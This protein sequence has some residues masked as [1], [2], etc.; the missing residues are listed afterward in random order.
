MQQESIVSV[1][2]SILLSFLLLFAVLS[3]QPG[4]M[5]TL[6]FGLFA[7]V[8]GQMLAVSVADARAKGVLTDVLLTVGTIAVLFTALAFFDTQNR[9]LGFGPYL[10]VALIGLIIARLIVLGFVVAD[11]GA[12][13]YGVSN[14]L[15]WFASGLFA[16]YLAY[17]TQLMKKRIAS[18][19]RQQHDY[20]DYALGPFLDI[21]NLFSAIEDLSS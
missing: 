1:L 3:L 18:A 5:K 9:F 10:F 19:K 15:S 2:I 11:K 14:T 21:V 17:D 12:S 16:V 7:I 20:V 6:L 4:P 8:L 13:V